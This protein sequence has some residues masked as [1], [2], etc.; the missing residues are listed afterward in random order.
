M[1][2]HIR[3]KEQ[4][5]QMI[6]NA[7]LELL[8]EKEYSKLTV[9]EI[10]KRADVARRTF[11]RL[12]DNKDSIIH[13]YFERLCNDYQNNYPPIE[14]YDI[15]QVAKDYFSFWYTQ[16]EQLLKFHRA[17]L[18]DM[19]YYGINNASTA[20]IRRRIGDEYLRYNTELEYFA[21]Y[22]TGGFINLLIGWI[23][24]GMKETPE[25]YAEM[26]SK[27]ILKYVSG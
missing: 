13:N 23:D 7:L 2:G 10:V 18:D 6:E 17:G 8:D 22:S 3:Q 15:K 26:V 19:L 16:R 27:A 9:S 11:Y 20:V 1:N 14:R 4:S 24:K 5:R 21:G 25:K 12:Y